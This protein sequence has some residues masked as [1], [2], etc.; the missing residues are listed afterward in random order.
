MTDPNSALQQGDSDDR[1]LAAIVYVLFI[2]GPANGLTMLIGGILA[3]LRYDKSPAWL[4]THYQFQLRTL[5]F[6]FVFF[7][8]GLLTVWILGLGLLV[9]A[10]GGLWVLIRAI[11][12]L[13]RLIDGR[14]HTDP[15]TLLI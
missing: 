2:I 13:V 14:A 9:W 7:V 8:I 12:G 5:F 15:S 3:A 11:V 4:K 10:A 1:I 6:G